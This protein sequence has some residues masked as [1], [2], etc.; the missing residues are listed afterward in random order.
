[1]NEPGF[2]LPAWSAPAHVR[3]LVTTRSGGCS[4]GA[5]SGM[6]LGDHVGD[7]PEAVAA[8]RAL[9][10]DAAPLPSEPC[11][12]RQVHGI[13]GV[14]ATAANS[15]APA[16]WSWADKSGQVCAV[17]TADCLPLLICDRQGRR[18]AAVHAGWR[19]LCSGIIDRAIDSFVAANIAPGDIL[20]WLGPAISAAAYEVDEPVYETFA[21][22]CP[23]VLPAFAV[24]APGRWQLDL[25]AAARA[26]LAERGVM[27]CSGGDFCTY[28]D[29]RFFSHR[30]EAP[31][32]RQA[33]LIWLEK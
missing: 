11:W 24:R 7:A 33:S 32:G 4:H 16:D 31:C 29:T 26:V 17:M 8:N 3:A 25:Y 13:N 18:V 12:L 21:R 30:R 23:V 2:V 22:Q 10:T 15:G 20:V 6:N 1:M 14:A 19:G 5:W 28:N 9:L 27:D